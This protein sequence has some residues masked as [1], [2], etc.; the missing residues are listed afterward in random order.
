KANNSCRLALCTR[1]TALASMLTLRLLS[2]W[3]KS[4]ALR[5]AAASMPRSG[6]IAM[7]LIGPPLIAGAC[8]AAVCGS[9]AGHGGERTLSRRQSV[10]PGGEK[11]VT[12]D[13]RRAA[14]SFEQFRG[15]EHDRQM[16][17]LAT[18]AGERL[19]GRA[20]LQAARVLD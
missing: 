14:T 20:A 7:A 19:A 10:S 12:I 3:G 9:Q 16:A 2:R 13:A 5:S 11:H 15:I 4:C 8:H 17:V 1:S 18:D 6:P